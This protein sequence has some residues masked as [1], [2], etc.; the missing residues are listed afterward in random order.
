MQTNRK[1]VLWNMVKECR[2]G[3]L[4]IPNLDQGAQVT[5]IVGDC[6]KGAVGSGGVEWFAHM[7]PFVQHLCIEY[8]SCDKLTE[9]GGF[10]MKIKEAFMTL[11]CLSDELMRF[12]FVKE[13]LFANAFDCWTRDLITTFPRE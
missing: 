3:T 6:V 8:V 9:G 2:C 12:E 4:G 1:D 7:L 10:L 11:M 13:F 5:V